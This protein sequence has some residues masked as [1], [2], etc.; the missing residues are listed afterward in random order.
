MIEQTDY[1][2]PIL[3]R[4]LSEKQRLGLTNAQI[5]RNSKGRLLEA[6]VN[7]IF[8]GKTRTP[9]IDTLLML[10][11]A[12]GIKLRDLVGD[13]IKIDVQAEQ[14]QVVV[15]TVD[16]NVYNQ[17]IQMYKDII[18]KNDKTYND[19][20]KSKDKTIKLLGVL[21]FI[22]MILAALFIGFDLATGEI[23]FFRY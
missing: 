6:T 21:L 5:A 20:I 23:G 22:F 15:P 16:A 8:T 10:C 14:P 11:D 13:D 1:F 4:L 3:D 9:G 2:Q 18:A 19:I 17:M 12:M 7:R